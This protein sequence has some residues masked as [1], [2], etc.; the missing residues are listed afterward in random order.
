MLRIWEGISATL[1]QGD[2]I[3]GSRGV[4]YEVSYLCVQLELGPLGNHIQCGHFM[5][6]ALLR[7]KGV[8][9][10]VHWILSFI[11]WGLCLGTHSIHQQTVSIRGYAWRTLWGGMGHIH[12]LDHDDVFTGI[13]APK[14]HQSAHFKCEQI[15]VCQFFLNKNFL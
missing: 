14:L 10:L 12:Y 8:G 9:M 3:K 11:S 5:C 13:Q 15:V 4:C 6:S 1:V 2:S 7:G